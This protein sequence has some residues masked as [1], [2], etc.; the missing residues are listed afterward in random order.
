MAAVA[1]QLVD[2]AAQ[3][4]RFIG[5]IAHLWVP[6]IGIFIALK[7]VLRRRLFVYGHSLG[8]A[9]AID[10]AAKHPDL[11]GIIGQNSFTSMADMVSRFRYTHLPVQWILHQ[12]FES[13]QKVSQLQVPILLI[14]AT[15]DPLIPTV[16]GERLYEAA[17]SFKGLVL[18]E[19][20][21]HHNAASQYKDS[22]YLIKIQTFAPRAILAAKAL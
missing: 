6:T 16:M 5:Q 13:L 17:R 11:A 12:R 20:N 10:L 18:V 21:V 2:L 9:I 22:R 8:G 3:L 15:G 7:L 4:L 19:S 1:S 14:H